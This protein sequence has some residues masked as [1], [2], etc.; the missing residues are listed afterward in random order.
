MS[1]RR[2]LPFLL[3]ALLLPALLLTTPSAT[4]RKA[5]PKTPEPDFI[6]R[7]D[8]VSARGFM[9]D[10]AKEFE[11]AH[12]GHITLQP[13]STISGL[14]AVAAGRADLAGTARGRYARRAEEAHI[15][16]IP[17]ALDA[18][19]A[20]THP[21][22][23]AHDISLAQ[24]RDVYLGKITNWKQLGGNDT[25]INLYAIAAPLDGVEFSLRALLF[26]NGDQ[27]V[28]APRLYLNTA[29]LEEGVTLDP[30]GLGL[31]TLSSSYA[32]KGVKMLSVEGVAPSMSHVADGSYPLFNTL[33]LGDDASTPN[34]P[35]VDAFIAFL[36]TPE[37]QRTMRR[38]QLVPY[39]EAGDVTALNAARVAHI[40]T[41]LFAGAPPS[42]IASAPPPPTQVAP[43]GPVAPSASPDA[44]AKPARQIT[45]TTAL[46]ER[47][48]V[49]AVAAADSHKKLAQRAQTSRHEPHAAIASN[50]KEARKSPK[51][52]A[53]EK[54]RLASAKTKTTAPG[55]AKPAKASF[56][57]VKTTVTTSKSAKRATTFGNVK[58]GTARSGG[59]E[60]PD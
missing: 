34:K 14:D 51:A 28:A 37:A 55:K 1:F 4:A 6:W 27:R 20:I 24:L 38:H 58:G 17:V 19:V 13:F 18:I 46:A 7:G 11:K 3:G 57:N 12:K 42:A 22:N 43:T 47:A 10:I 15:D 52:K 8:I 5:H 49:S 44:A 30:A 35:E 39:A 29:K 60:N 36:A 25:P 50:H 45:P 33:Y 56:D 2:S 31:S 48:N 41:E 26:H 16:F 9:D 32:N 40:D 23:P 21:R 59:D 53:H 54:V